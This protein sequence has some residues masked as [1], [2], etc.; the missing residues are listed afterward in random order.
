MSKKGKRKAA[1]VATGYRFFEAF[2][3][4]QMRLLQER[5]IEV[6]AYAR[7]D[8]GY[9]GVAAQGVICHDISFQRS[10]FKRENL[11]ALRELTDSFRQ[12][13]FQLVHVH[14]PVGSIL[15]RLAAKRAKVPAVLYTAHGFHFFKGAPMLN[16]L[17][18]YPAEWWMARCTDRLITINQE[19]ARRADSLPVRG[20]IDSVPGV[21]IETQEFQLPE[22]VWHRLM[23][24]E[25]L[26][27]PQYEFVILCVAELN[28]NK[29][30]TQLLDAVHRMALDGRQ[31][32]LLL[33]GIGEAEERLRAE[34]AA[35]GLE[36]Y[37]RFLGFRRDI[38]ELLAASDA[39]ALV[40]KREGLPCCLMEA[41]AAGKPVVAT[42]VRGN[43]DLICHGESGL[44][45]PVGDGEATARA[46]IQLD[47]SPLLRERLGKQAQRQARRYDL[48]FVLRQ[49]QHIYG[50]ALGDDTWLLSGNDGMND[51]MNVGMRREGSGG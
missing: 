27:V 3:V 41:M 23:K 24:R 44:L 25:Q 43:R 12:E 14:T 40:S 13:M 36:G 31:V 8:H 48:G 7:P 32:T 4:P 45:V 20:K 51:G 50:E 28:D 22:P 15:G 1:F 33:V 5:G 35:R 42:D 17:L 46:L 26:G 10:P 30:Q 19:D 2:T 18:Y 11:Q 6:H 49:M 9:A 38:A 47:D 39:A 21:G 37:V 34:V 16:W 29:N